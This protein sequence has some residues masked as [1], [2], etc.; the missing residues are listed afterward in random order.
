MSE[1]ANAGL[2][3]YRIDGREHPFRVSAR[4][5]TCRS[6]HRLEID[7]KLVRG[8]PHSAIIRALPDGCCLTAANLGEHYRRGHVAAEHEIAR[9][10]HDEHAEAIG[11]EVAADA[12]HV[13]T[14]RALAQRVLEMVFERMA[15]GEIR[16][17]LKEGLAAA[18]ILAQR[19]PI[20]ADRDRLQA[21]LWGCHDEIVSLFGIAEEIMDDDQWKRFGRAV[22]FYPTLN[23]LRFRYER[24]M[25]AAAEKEAAR[26]E[27]ARTPRK[28]KRTHG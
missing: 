24:E 2:S 3:T 27:R 23:G 22:D 19:D 16:A 18:R 7:G 5:R 6:P 4:C 20:V 15:S 17:T 13:L 28:T 25:E 12:E 10:I 1:H 8:E 9:R 11:R 14:E 26:Q 21:L